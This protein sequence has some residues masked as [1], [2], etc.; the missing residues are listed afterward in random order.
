MH[1]TAFEFLPAHVNKVSID[2]TTLQ[3]A[4]SLAIEDLQEVGIQVTQDPQVPPMLVVELDEA[5][6]DDQLAN[7]LDMAI[8]P[9]PTIPTIPMPTTTISVG[10]TSQWTMQPMRRMPQLQLQRHRSNLLQIRCDSGY[11]NDQ[12]P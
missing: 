3:R 9:S 12:T 10:S 5:E 1:R 7:R 2:A 6:L 4:R 11:L 8:S